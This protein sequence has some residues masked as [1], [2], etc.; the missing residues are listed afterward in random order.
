MLYSKI[1]RATVT[2]ANIDYVGSISM[3]IDLIESAKLLE[4][5]KVDVLNINNGER[6]STYV[7]PAPRGSCE[8]CINGAA[9]RLAQ[10]GDNVIIIA[11]MSV[12][13]EDANTIKPTIIFVD[14]N[15]RIKE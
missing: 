4:G 9:A 14:E 5:M 2:G 12:N 11:Y 13:L 15:N 7:I 3:D 8:I 1:H 10:K 6:F